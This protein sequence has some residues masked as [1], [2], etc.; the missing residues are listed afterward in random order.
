MVRRM[1]EDVRPD[2]GIV[3][4][5]SGKEALA[6]AR[7]GN[8]DCILLDF[9]LPDM[10]GTEFMAD[11]A[12]HPDGG[13]VS[14]PLVVLTGSEEDS[15]AVAS[16]QHGAE[17]YVVKGTITGNGLARVV[18]NAIEKFNIRRELEEKRTALQLRQWEL[19]MV[20]E[21]LLSRLAELSHATRAKDQFLSVMSH[22]M[23]TPLNAILGYADLMEM[24][25]GGTLTD[26]QQL[27]LA[28]IR[29]GGRHLLDLI[30]DVLD[31]ARADAKPASLEVWPID[32]GSVIA[33][34]AA[35]L[36]NQ[37]QLK[38]LTLHI[39]VCDTLPSV[40]ADLQRLRQ[41]LMNV[42]GNAIKFTEQGSITIRCSSDDASVR[43][44]VIDTGIG[45]SQDVLALVFDDFYQADGRYKRERGGTGLGLAITQRLIRQ[46]GGDIV[47]ESSNGAGS[48]FTIS[49]P[50]AA[51]A[52]SPVGVDYSPADAR[53][54]GA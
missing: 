47:A 11:L 17:D 23:R 39:D 20:R 32:A 30:A 53:A 14:L 16:L 21:E 25:I 2:Y 27:H 26:V 46:M 13:G 3:F 12:E 50:I 29:V 42:I 10:R 45:M 34:V 22:E 52:A 48:T 8:F 31:L 15:V 33:E 40:Q 38:G 6:L 35:L 51:R 49:L 9:Y 41:G 43:I 18:E 4:A 24:Q 1:L 5:Q 54:V 36:E 7:D 19:E 37:A 44:A 28:R